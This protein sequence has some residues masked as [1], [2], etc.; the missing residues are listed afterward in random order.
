MSRSTSSTGQ[1][2]STR[3]P[4][5]QSRNTQPNYW[6]IRLARACVAFVAWTANAAARF[7]CFL[8]L[9]ITGPKRQAGVV[10]AWNRRREN[11]K[12]D[13]LVVAI[14]A[15]YAVVI[16]IMA[17]VNGDTPVGLVA[18]RFGPIAIA[19]IDVGPLDVAS[20]DIRSV[21]ARFGAIVGRA[22]ANSALRLLVGPN[23]L[24]L[25]LVV[26]IVAV[27]I[28][29]IG[30]HPVV[31]VV[32]LI[33][34][35]A[36]TLLLVEARAGVAEHSEIMIGE[37][38]IIFGLDAVARLLRVAR[39][40]LVFFMQLGGIAALPI[41]L[42]IAA[43]IIAAGDASGLLSTPTATAAALTIIDQAKLPRRTGASAP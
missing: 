10:V 38:Q 25:I 42:A 28:I 4:T 36:R 15:R 17:A 27:V 33:V 1:K 7:G 30:I 29:H 12:I 9:V 6:P 43:I 2:R 41:I 19:P 39:H 26:A 40:T 32:I 14:V 31:A 11:R 13:S 24:R 3:P 37:L 5:N 16:A 21:T 23:A 8:Y 20:V 18:A 34:I 35:V 22:W